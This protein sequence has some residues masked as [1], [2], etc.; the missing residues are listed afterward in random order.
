MSI[1]Y[2]PV[3]P[4]SLLEERGS[5]DMNFTKKL[6][7][8][9]YLRLGVVV[10]I[11]DIEDKEN[12][13]KLVPEYDVMTIE[14][15]N[16]TNYK[17]CMSIDSFGGVADFFM[18]KLRKPKD[19]KKV[20]AK[21]SL[22]NQ[23]GSIVLLL[24]IDGNSEQA[25]ILGAIA[26]PDRKTGQ[27]KKALGH[28]A[29]GEFNGLNYK[30]DKD[31][32]LTILFKSATDNDGKP[33]DTKAGGS[34]W[35]IEKDGSIQFSDGNKEVVRLDKTK[36]TITVVAESDISITSDA[37]VNLTAKKNISAKA[38]ADLIAEAGGSFTAK[39]GG[40]FNVTSDGPMSLKAPDLKIAVDNMFQLKASTISLSAP[41]IMIGDGGTPAIILTT[42]FLG[43]GNLG[44]P[45]ISQAI[46]PFSATV[47]I[48]P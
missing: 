23:N 1:T 3:L 39:S 25:V 12:V 8:N 35:K 15:D 22:K 26:H 47:F 31:G 48:A 44:A 29:E 37:N 45:V 33:S 43:I 34:T 11:Y 40:P 18:A 27:L 5:M 41:S 30:V 38:A 42:Q 9:M 7:E 19:S 21:G 46:G 20:K 36:K 13:S 28:H 2:K 16:T 24:C 14:D 32:A 6:S 4:S 17:N 10:E